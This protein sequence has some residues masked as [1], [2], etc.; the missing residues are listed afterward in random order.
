MCVIKDYSIS[1][2]IKVEIEMKH[3]VPTFSIPYPV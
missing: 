1:I 3:R 2:L